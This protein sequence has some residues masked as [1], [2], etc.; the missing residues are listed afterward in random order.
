MTASTALATV[1]AAH[2][3]RLVPGPADG[4]AG[5]RRRCLSLRCATHERG[6]P[7]AH[8]DAQGAGVSPDPLTQPG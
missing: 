4:T 5:G 7:V 2:V 6:R 3:G 8:T 1:R